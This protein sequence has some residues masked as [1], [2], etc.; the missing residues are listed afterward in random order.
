M[1]TVFS[2]SE[3]EFH[4]SKLQSHFSE[5]TV[6]IWSLEGSGR[7]QVC[8]GKSDSVRC[9]IRKKHPAQMHLQHKSLE[10]K[11]ERL[12][13]LHNVMPRQISTSCMKNREMSAKY[14]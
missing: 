4:L 12:C 6:E 9:T 10:N 7:I 8:E 5:A 1:D 11:N 3:L 2:I 14:I 13:V